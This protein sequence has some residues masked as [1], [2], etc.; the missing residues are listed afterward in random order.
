MSLPNV[1]W[2]HLGLKTMNGVFKSPAQSTI[3]TTTLRRVVGGVY[4][5]ADADGLSLALAATLDDGTPLKV[6]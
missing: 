3:V 2:E 4:W 5:I 1:Y 6:A